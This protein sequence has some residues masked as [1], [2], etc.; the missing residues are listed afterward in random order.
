MLTP[1]LHAKKSV[2]VENLAQLA[3]A[4]AQD[5]QIIKMKAGVY[6]MR[7][8]LNADTIASRVAREE[9]QYF[10]FSGSGNQIDMQGVTFEIDTELRVLLKHPIHTNEIIVSGNDN[11]LKGLFIK[12]IG[13]AV[14]PGGCAFTVVGNGN[15][16]EE[17]TLHVQGSS[18][19]G[20][21]D[22]FGKGKAHIIKHQKHSGFLINGEGTTA[23]GCKV[24]MRSF[25]HAFFIQQKPSDVTLID[26]Y[27]EGEIR[28]TADILA[29]TEGAAFDVGFRTLTKNRDGEFIV[30][31]GYTKSLCEE[32]FRTYGACKNLRFI[33]CTAK[34]TRGG[35]E[36]R[37]WDE[38]IYLEDCTTIGT[39]RA[40]WVGEGAIVKGCKGDA[41]NGPLLF[42]EGGNCEIELELVASESEYIV[43]G[44]ATI[45][46]DNNRVIINPY[47]G[48]QQ[49]RDLPIM[50][51]Y[52]QPSNGEP[53][54]PF[55]Q[56]RC[57]GLTLVNNTTMSTVVGGEC[58]DYQ[59]KSCGEV[60]DAPEG[61]Y[62]GSSEDVK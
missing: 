14:S 41:C 16:I 18:P 51:G 49:Q 2:K 10:I 7:D 44:L 24:Y 27:A 60:A 11:H 30:T 50:V 40:Y 58:F 55:S 6:S 12:H 23:I 25:G 48:V 62:E 31:A 59:I 1:S 42:V 20:Y 9:Y 54:S 34:N 45:L 56:A 35:F 3:E 61:L 43:N 13:D 38:S 19:Y 21:G 46:G 4:V 36:L 33:R 15:T 47:K 52:K 5:N 53:M 26:C 22:L 8:Y 37:S 28:E 17:F 57:K 32:G 29:E 39:E